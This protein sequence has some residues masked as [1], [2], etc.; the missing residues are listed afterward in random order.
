MRFH[1]SRRRR[2]P[3]G[4]SLV[5][6]AIVVPLM[7]LLLAA[8]IDL[9]RLFYAYVA[10]ENAA[11]EGAFFGA[12]SPL[13]DDATGSGCT[14][15]NNVAWHVQHEATNI[16]SQFSTTVACRTP[17]GVLVQPINDCLDGYTY[18]VSVTYPF[19]LIT[20]ILGSIVNQNLTLRSESQATVLSD[21]FDPSGLEMLV[22]VSY[23]GADNISAISAACTQADAT[24]APNFYFGPCQD[25][26][27]V[28]NFLQFQENTT[29]TYKVRVR[30]T[31]NLALSGVAYTWAANGSSIAAPGTCGTLPTTIAKA[32]APAYCTFTRR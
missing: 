18:Q 26:N 27:N 22:W 5:E 25:P 24:N 32:A 3:R 23:T 9:G 29:V 19:R 21:A 30:N 31:G 11:K 15:P 1:P 28:D 14:D 4:Q 13:C 10:V 7:L 17:A 16:G 12:R 20:P 8:A 6:F 2:V